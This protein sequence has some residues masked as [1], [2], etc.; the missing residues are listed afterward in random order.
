MWVVRALGPGESATDLVTVGGADVQS[1][2]G[3]PLAV[4]SDEE[5]EAGRY[6]IT[7]GGSGV[8]DGF[9]RIWL[10]VGEEITWTDIYIG[11]GL[12]A[13]PTGAVNNAA[14]RQI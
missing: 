10:A 7:W 13:Q 12:S 14:P 6:V 5:T 4:L 3:R 2:D 8:R 1:D 11:E 9:Y